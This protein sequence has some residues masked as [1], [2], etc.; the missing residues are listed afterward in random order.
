MPKHEPTNSYFY[1]AIQLAKRMMRADDFDFHVDHVRM[2]ITGTQQIHISHVCYLD[3]RKSKGI[4][5]DK[6]LS[7]FC[8]MDKS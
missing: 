2:K 7:K 5:T 8:S 3:E 1:L 4:I 6:N